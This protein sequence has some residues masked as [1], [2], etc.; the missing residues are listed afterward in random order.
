MNRLKYL[1]YLPQ[2]IFFNLYYLPFKQAIRLPIILYKVKFK[3]LKGRIV[4]DTTNIRTGM[5]QLGPKINSLYE[6]NRSWFIWE[7]RGTCCFKGSCI[8]GHNSAI[9]TGVNGYLEFG[10]N[11]F[12]G[13]TL[14]IACYKSIIIGE[15][16]H[17][18]WEVIL[19]DTDFHE[20]IN[21]LSKERSEATKEIRL[22]KNNWIGIRTI[23]LKGTRTPDFCIAG[24]SSLLNKNY[25]IPEYSLIAGNPAKLIKTGIYRDLNSNIR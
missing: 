14:R 21:I 16:T 12:V 6:T 20:T 7:H 5:I 8:I 25:D 1:I 13:T 18:A 2:T 15:N 4:I 24:A 19:I 22:G 23:I 11:V 9:S 17:F 3:L 10:N